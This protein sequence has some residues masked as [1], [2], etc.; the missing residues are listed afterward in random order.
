M[1]EYDVVIIGGG[2]HGAGVLQAAVAAGKSVPPA[3]Q[4]EEWHRALEFYRQAVA[5][6]D[7]IVARPSIDRDAGLS[8]SQ[9]GVERCA[10]MLAAIERAN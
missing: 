8:R 9:A 10:K 1:K 6:W 5:A 4:R 7:P 3:Q 2:I